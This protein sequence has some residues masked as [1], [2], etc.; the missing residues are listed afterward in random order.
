[1]SLTHIEW[2]S[3]VTSNADAIDVMIC[4]NGQFVE[5]FFTKFLFNMVKIKF[6]VGLFHT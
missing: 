2:S 5:I 6:I 3:N 1:M 4:I